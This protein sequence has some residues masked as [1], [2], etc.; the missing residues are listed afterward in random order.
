MADKMLELHGSAI[1]LNIEKRVIPGGVDQEI[2]H[3]APSPEAKSAIRKRFSLPTDAFIV[4]S[5]RR[6]I[7]R[8]G[9]DL[10]IQAFANLADNLKDNALLVLTGDGASMADLKRLSAESGLEKK[11]VFTGHVTESDLADYYRSADLFALP[12]RELEGFGLSTVE[13]MA[14]GLPVIGTDIGGTPEILS[15]I[16][17]DLLIPEPTAAAISAKLAEFIAMDDLDDWRRKSLEA[18]EERHT[19]RAHV[20]SFLD[21]AEQLIKKRQ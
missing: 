15:R 1:P 5:S 10:L 21:F 2:F 7:P 17:R 16:S 4:I 3:P 14:S 12:T 11:I 9:L 6:M 20:D 19:W 8:T 18:V 13:A